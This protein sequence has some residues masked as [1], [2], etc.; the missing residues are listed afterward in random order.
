[1]I[2]NRLSDIS[3]LSIQKEYIKEVTANPQFYGDVIDY[4]A[5]CKNRRIPLIFK[6]EQVIQLAEKLQTANKRG[7]PNKKK[8]P[9]ANFAA[10]KPA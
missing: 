6:A 1:M 10:S 4:F 3:L 8:S 2:Q 5:N 9:R 7:I